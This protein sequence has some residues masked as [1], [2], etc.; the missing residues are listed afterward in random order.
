MSKENCSAAEAVA[1]STESKHTSNDCH[2]TMDCCIVQD[3]EAKRSA[4]SFP[5][6]IDKLVIHE[7]FFA[8]KEELESL[9]QVGIPKALRGE[10]MFI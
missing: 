7:P 9:V 10:V 1:D 3:S 2:K 4:N 8:W 6:A 5:N